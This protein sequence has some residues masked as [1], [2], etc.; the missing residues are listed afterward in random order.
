MCVAKYTGVRCAAGKIFVHKILNDKAAKFFPYIKNIMGKT[1]F[2]CRLPGIV[3]TVHIAAAC[4][5]FTATTGRIVP[6]FHGNAYHFIPFIMQ[7]Q[8]GNGTVN[9]AAHGHQHFPFSAHNSK[10]CK[11]QIYDDI[12]DVQDMNSKETCR[13][14]GR[15]L[16]IFFLI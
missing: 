12:R 9:T 2:Y 3:K 16:L 13:Q 7:H 1:M 14:K 11:L 8:G 5:F 4:F 15:S 10:I 6:C